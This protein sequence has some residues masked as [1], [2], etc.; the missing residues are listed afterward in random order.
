MKVVAGIVLFNPDLQ[1]LNENINAVKNQVEQIIF[2]DNGSQNWNEIKKF[3]KKNDLENN[4]KVLR[5]K[6]NK[7]IAYALNMIAVYAMNNGY[8]WL[9]TLDQDTVIKKDLITKYS[10]FTN[11]KNIGQLSC[12]YKD[13]NSNKIYNLISKNKKYCEVKECITSGALLNLRALKKIGGFDTDL[14]IDYVDFELCFAL[15]KMGLKTYAINYVGMLHEVG[16]I[17]EVKI[18]QHVSIVLNQSSFRH[19]YMTRNELIVARRYPNEETLKYALIIQ[20]KVLGKVILFENNKFSKVNSILRGAKDGL[21]NNYSRSRDYL[22]EMN[23]E[24]LCNYS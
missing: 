3:F 15:R 7:G 5:S 19:Y 24:S 12:A 21:T 20:L 14:F 13:R 16:H 18:G 9:L 11:L 4:I 2:F 22:K 23:Y 8:E 17:K 6:N 1:R 10:S